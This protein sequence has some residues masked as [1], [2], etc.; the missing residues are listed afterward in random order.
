M[1]W[2][3]SNINTFARCPRL[4]QYKYVKRRVPIHKSDSLMLG[5]AVHEGL[6]AWFSEGCTDKARQ[7]VLEC[8]EDMTPQV[9]YRALGMV[10]GYMQ[11]YADDNFVVRAVEE[12]V[13]VTLGGQ[14]FVVKM[15]GL[16]EMGG[17]VYVLE[18]KTTGARIGETDIY[19]QQREMDFQIDLYL[20]AAEQLGYK[21]HGVLYDVLGK[22]TLKLLKKETPEEHAERVATW[23]LKPGKL[24]RA[25]Y[26]RSDEQ[27]K[28]T[29]ADVLGF[30]DM[31]VAAKKSGVFPRNL[32][33][34]FDY[35]KA[36]EYLPVCQGRTTLDDSRLYEVRKRR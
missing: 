36:C 6:E 32:G 12:L 34:C 20:L 28:Q 7:A 25:I 29:N 11:H 30:V 19:W 16:I 35:N 33:R 14:K 1:I 2:S 23:M 21:P 18:H 26:L 8:T 15:D 4:W 24:K 22:C 9:R 5:T 17:L 27:L 31:A 13:H 3:A 10:M